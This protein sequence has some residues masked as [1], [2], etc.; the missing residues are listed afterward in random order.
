MSLITIPGGNFEL[1]FR[2]SGNEPAQSYLPVA[3]REGQDIFCQAS[4]TKW[5]CIDN[6]VQEAL[7]WK[8]IQFVN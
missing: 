1:Y 4:K 5:T 8:Q 2:E 6:S 7:I 3:I